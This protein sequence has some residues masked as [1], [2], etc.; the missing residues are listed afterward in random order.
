MRRKKYTSKSKSKKNSKQLRAYIKRKRAET[1]VY[2]QRHFVKLTCIICERVDKFQRIKVNDIDIYTPETT[3]DYICLLCKDTW[4]Y[5]L[6]EKGLLP[7]KIIQT[8]L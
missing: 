3:K 7:L 6:W 2:E 8:Y 1:G 5:R 4:Q